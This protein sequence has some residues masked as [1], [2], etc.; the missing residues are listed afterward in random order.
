MLD[1]VHQQYLP[2]IE[3]YQVWLKYQT[4]LQREHKAGFLRLFDVIYK[5]FPHF[6]LITA[7]VDHIL[8][9]HEEEVM[10]GP[11]PFPLIALF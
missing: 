8:E 2:G 11:S 4:Q 3:F 7:C 6:Q 5:E 9:L 10:V 1:L